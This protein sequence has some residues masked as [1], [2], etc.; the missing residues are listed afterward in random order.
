MYGGPIM[1]AS[2][3]GYQIGYPSTQYEGSPVSSYGI[4]RFPSLTPV[5]LAPPSTIARTRT[6]SRQEIV[7]YHGD[8]SFIVKAGRGHAVWRSCRVKVR[9]LRTPNCKGITYRRSSLAV[10]VAGDHFGMMAACIDVMS[11]DVDDDAVIKASVNFLTW[12]YKIFLLKLS[13]AE[14]SGRTG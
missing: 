1:H 12:W 2:I 9:S 10:C 13:A 8:H 7:L 5:M 14:T 4:L 6:P 11:P 3:P